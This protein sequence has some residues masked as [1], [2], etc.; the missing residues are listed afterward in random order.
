MYYKPAEYNFFKTYSQEGFLMNGETVEDFMKKEVQ[1]LP[2]EFRELKQYFVKP[3][4]VKCE[5]L[6]GHSID[7]WNVFQKD[8]YRIVYSDERNIFG[9][10]FVNI[11]QDLIYLGGRGTLKDA[12]TAY[13]Q[14]DNKE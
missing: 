2:E 9:I 13:I 4:K 7:I 6:N 12:V 8:E 1:L 14:R 11:L 10:A 5:T 3:E